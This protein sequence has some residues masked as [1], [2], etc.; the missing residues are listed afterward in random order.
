MERRYTS[1]P[2]TE[3][4]VQE[5]RKAYA[6]KVGNGEHEPA[7]LLSFVQ[8]EKDKEPLEL[9]SWAQQAS[10]GHDHQLK[11]MRLGWVDMEAPTD[12]EGVKLIE[13][14]GQYK[15]II[16]HCR[17]GEGRTGTA[18]AI[19]RIAFEG[20]STNH[21]QAE[22]ALNGANENQLSWIGSFGGRSKT[23][24]SNCSRTPT[25]RSPS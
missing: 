16:N 24:A 2:T 15:D 3:L 23:G 4:E 5:L 13:L 12:A 22:A 21:A 6:A 9:S 19:H 10:A 1:Q 20:W 17:A 14:Y 25:S 8:K 18:R 7:L 11:P